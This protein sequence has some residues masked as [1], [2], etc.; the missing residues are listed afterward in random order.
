MEPVGRQGGMLLLWSENVRVCQLIKSEFC[1][2]VEIEGP[3]FIG[4]WWIV[5]V[6]ASTDVA[7]R[8]RQ[9]DFLNQSEGAWGDKWLLGGDCNDML[10]LADKHGG[11]RRTEGSFS[12]FRNFVHDMQM[13]EIMFKGRRWTWANNRQGEGFIEERIDWFF[14]SAG[15]ILEAENAVV[16]HLLSYTSDHSM[17]MLDTHPH[18]TKLKSRFIYDSRWSKLNGCT[19]VIQ[20]NWNKQVTGSRM[21]KFQSKLIMCQIRFN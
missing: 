2:E 10:S 19:E 21:F 14:G 17:L 9:W 20:D 15:W 5:F 8:G 4:S 11:R 13:V 16:H 1:L 18:Q 3:N 7:T 12:Q 6:Y